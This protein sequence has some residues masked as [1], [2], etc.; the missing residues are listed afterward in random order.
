MTYFSVYHC[1]VSAAVM[2]TGSHNPS[3]EN[4][5][6]IAVGQGTIFGEEIRKLHEIMRDITAGKITSNEI[7]QSSSGQVHYFDIVTPYLSMLREKINL[8]QRC[9]KLAVD[10]GNGTASLFAQRVLNSWG[11]AGAV[12]WCYSTASLT[13]A[14]RTTSPTR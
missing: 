14:S 10:C 5:F 7:T 12:M 6:K 9:L 2:I 4:G 13:V 8:G 11:C 1:G 3:D